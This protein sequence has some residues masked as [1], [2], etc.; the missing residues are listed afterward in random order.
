VTFTPQAIAD[1]PFEVSQL[2]KRIS[3]HPLWTCIIST[4]TLG[5]ARSL[6]RQAAPQSASN[7][8]ECA[9]LIGVTELCEHLYILNLN[10]GHETLLQPFLRA[11]EDR[12]IAVI[13]DDIRKIAERSGDFLLAGLEAEALFSRSLQQGAL[14]DIARQAFKK[15]YAGI[16]G[17]GSL[18]NAVLGNVM[19]DMFFLQKHPAVVE[20]FRRFVVIKSTGDQGN[21]EPDG[22]SI[23]AVP[24]SMMA[25]ENRSI[26]S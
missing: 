17:P 22:V 10:S 14:L 11:V 21:L 7:S 19:K 15:R 6:I 20:R 4:S 3:S 23:K 18:K 9:S 26:C 1:G 13:N 5:A 8:T 16:S 12:Q 24:L 2:I 25:D